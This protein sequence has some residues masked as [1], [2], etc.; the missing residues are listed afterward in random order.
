MSSQNLP[1]N[2]LASE[3]ETTTT[4]QLY[5]KRIRGRGEKSRI[6]LAGKNLDGRFLVV[7]KVSTKLYLSKSLNVSVRVPDCRSGS[8]RA[9]P[10]N[11]KK[12]KKKKKKEEEKKKKKTGK[13]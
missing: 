11:K 2:I 8:N 12:K 6:N 4:S 5:L 3:E 7:G 9:D 13:R 1:P 10:R